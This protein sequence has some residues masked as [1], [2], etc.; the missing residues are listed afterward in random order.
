MPFAP[1]FVIAFFSFVP[2][3]ASAQS[4][5]PSGA[6][7]TG[8]PIQVDL[9]NQVFPIHPV[10][11]NAIGIEPRG[12][13]LVSKY[14]EL[15]VPQNTRVSGATAVDGAN[16]SPRFFSLATRVP[17]PKTDLAHLQT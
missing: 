6:T 9:Y 3:V 15:S 2:T 13:S 1:H 17:P 16:S 8:C 4:R 10:P 7:Y 12:R 11:R 14:S 5:G